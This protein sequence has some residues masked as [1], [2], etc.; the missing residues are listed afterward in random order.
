M[1]ATW[2]RV[3]NAVAARI[4][5][6]GLADPRVNP[7]LPLAV[8]RHRSLA[9]ALASVPRYPAVYV[10]REDARFT[11]TPVAAG[12]PNADGSFGL[13]DRAY[14]VYVWLVDRQP[15]LTDAGLDLID[16]WDDP[17]ANAFGAWPPLPAVA[18]VWQVLVEPLPAV[19]PGRGTYQFVRSGMVLRCVSREPMTGLAP[20]A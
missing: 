18:S 15:E 6:L 10:T 19:D 9:G 2:T 12:G 17:I 5:A 4:A 14:P 3:Q 8:I 20:A 7:A 13:K 16:G 1:P 11:E